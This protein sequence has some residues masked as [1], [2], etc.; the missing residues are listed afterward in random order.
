MVTFYSHINQDVDAHILDI[1]I[2]VILQICNNIIY[3][4]WSRYLSHTQPFQDTYPRPPACHMIM[5]RQ[6]FT[7]LI[8]NVTRHPS[9]PRLVSNISNILCHLRGK[10]SY[11]GTHYGLTL[12]PLPPFPGHL[13]HCLGL[14][15]CHSL[16]YSLYNHSRPA[17]KL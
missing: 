3:L 10:E 9:W 12:N 6:T 5:P 2:L 7:S 15:L 17:K 8:S 4:L 14:H 16:P 1:C 11:Q 13:Q